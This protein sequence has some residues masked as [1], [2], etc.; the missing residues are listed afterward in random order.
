MTLMETH[1]IRFVSRSNPADNTS[2]TILAVQ[3][4]SPRDFASQTA[5]NIK[6]AWAV[7]KNLILFFQKQEDGKFVITRD[8]ERQAIRVHA[9]TDRN[10]NE[11][12]DDEVEDRE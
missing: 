4:Y 3:D 10:L 1:S 11:A 2:H 8:L 12:S 7:V 9:M 6:N 5:I